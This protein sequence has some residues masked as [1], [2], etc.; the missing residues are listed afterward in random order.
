MLKGFM[1]ETIEPLLLQ[2][3]QGFVKLFAEYEETLINTS[4]GPGRG[5]A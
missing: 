4:V 2:N 3:S 1:P 5:M